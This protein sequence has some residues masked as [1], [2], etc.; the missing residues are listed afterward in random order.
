[1]QELETT[2]SRPRAID[3]G[4]NGNGDKDDASSWLLFDGQG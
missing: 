3:G 2:M 4:G 1:M